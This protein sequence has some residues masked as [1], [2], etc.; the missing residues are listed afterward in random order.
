MLAHA[1]DSDLAYSFRRSPSAMLAAFI[2]LVLAVGALFAPWLAPHN[3]MDVASLSLLDSFKPPIGMDGADWSNLLGTDNQG[4][5]VLSAIMYGMRI[6]L[7]V[8]LLST[9]FA[10]V[11]GIGVGLLAGYAGGT[12]DAVL[13]RVADIQLTFPSIL[14]ALLVDGVITA[15]LPQTLRDAVQIYVIIFAI[16]ISL[17][18]NFARTVRGSTLVERNKDYVMA[19]R[20]IGVPSWR[21][22]LSHVLPNVIGPVLVIATLGLGLAVIAEATLSFLGVGL[23]PTQ[24]SLGTLIRFGDD[25]LFSGQWWVTVFPGL[26]L[27][28]LV[29]AI[30]LLGDWLRDALNPKL[31]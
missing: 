9:L 29:L 5:D 8:G 16:G 18:P 4:R 3:P 1:W 10:M 17:W 2:A 30:N 15:A 20:V 27:V 19:A 24:P 12:T 14:T 21:I 22:M 23:P 11:V 31:R 6:S 28:L 13:M 26:A 7:S 25:Y